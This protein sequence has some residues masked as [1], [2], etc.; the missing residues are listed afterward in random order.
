MSLLSPFTEPLNFVRMLTV[1]LRLK[2]DFELVQAWMLA[3]LRIQQDWLVQ[4]RDEEDVR[5]VMREWEEVHKRE[6]ERTGNLVGYVGGV[7]GFIRGI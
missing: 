6:R 7:L 1:H 2:K 4:M 5:S 3:F